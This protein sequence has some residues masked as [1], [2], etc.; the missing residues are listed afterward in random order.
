MNREAGRTIVH[1]VT[2]S[3]TR[4]KQLST[5]CTQESKKRL[6]TGPGKMHAQ[7]RHMRKAHVSFH[8]GLISSFGLDQLTTEGL[9]WYRTG[10]Q[11]L[12]KVDVFFKCPIL[13]K[14]HKLP[15]KH[16][17]FEGTK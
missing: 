9:L 6:P 1:G 12:R 13:H 16:A 3:Q 11:S 2:Q 10:M 7:L 4:L 17:P 8:P 5:Q 15:G 14:V